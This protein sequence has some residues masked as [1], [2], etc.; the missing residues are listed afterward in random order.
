MVYVHQNLLGYLCMLR[1]RCK[2]S[3]VNELKMANK[4]AEYY[5]IGASRLMS[6][7]SLA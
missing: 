4:L 6:P 2:P 7:F 3:N 5:V 1:L